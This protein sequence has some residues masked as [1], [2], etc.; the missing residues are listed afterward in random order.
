VPGRPLRGT[1]SR[2][3]GR[4]NEK[5]RN[6]PGTSGPTRCKDDSKSWR[7]QG[8]LSTLSP[9]PE[10]LG[11][12]T[13]AAASQK[14]GQKWP[15]RSV[16]R[17]NIRQVIEKWRDKKSLVCSELL[18]CVLKMEQTFPI[19]FGRCHISRGASVKCLKSQPRRGASRTRGI[20]VVKKCS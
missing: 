16:F 7:S 12:E 14:S 1:N 19:W 8:V 4:A 2:T 11:F 6:K 17:T 3:A 18:G 5:S 20:G 15:E 13:I 10:P 9:T